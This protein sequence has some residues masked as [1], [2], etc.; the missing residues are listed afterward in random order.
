MQQPPPAPA[1]L[2]SATLARRSPAAAVEPGADVAAA[3]AGA[4]PAVAVAVAAAP[5]VEA[6][7]AQAAAGVEA[8]RA[9]AVALV[10]VAGAVVPAGVV[11]EEVRASVGAARQR[12][13]MRLAGAA[14][15]AVG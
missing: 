2:A 15:A 9:E 13:L 6:A 1:T 14:G 10:E 3:A 11:A 12:A 7:P 5:P 8:A 4:E